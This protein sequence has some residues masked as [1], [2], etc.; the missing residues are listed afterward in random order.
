M[1]TLSLQS[2]M[3]KHSILVRKYMDPRELTEALC[4]IL[5]LPSQDHILGFRDASGN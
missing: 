2:N 5:G 1:Y 4:L 3:N